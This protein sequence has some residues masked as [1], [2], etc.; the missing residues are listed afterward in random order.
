MK[1]NYYVLSSFLDLLKI[2]EMLLEY[3]GDFGK[4]KLNHTNEDNI[5]ANK[6]KE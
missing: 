3:V 1:V 4:I 6:N 5:K 2:E